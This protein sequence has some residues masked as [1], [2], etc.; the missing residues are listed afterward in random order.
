[1]KKE[2][3]LNEEEKESRRRQI[4]ENR[5]KKFGDKRK[6]SNGSTI[7]TLPDIDA[8][9]T[10]TLLNVMHSEEITD[11]VETIK[12]FDINDVNM[13]SDK[14]TD[15]VDEP[16]YTIS[17][18]PDKLMEGVAKR[19]DLTLQ[20]LVTTLK[21]LGAFQSLSLND[22]I[23]MV[24]HNCFELEILNAGLGFNH[25]TEGWI[26]KGNNFLALLKYYLN[27]IA[28][29]FD[30]DLHILGLLIPVILFN[31]ERPNI[32]HKDMIELQQ[33]LYLYL[34]Q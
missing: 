4:E 11:Y 3:I 21:N 31:P 23:A 29:E 32:I 17:I 6:A 14:T 10:D 22:Q 8:Q 7:C 19:F 9:E 20:K 34:L 12:N 2:W 16:I 18:S 27:T 33:Q 24:K 15:I 25:K 1:M 26:F 5:I 13:P 30:S 28:K